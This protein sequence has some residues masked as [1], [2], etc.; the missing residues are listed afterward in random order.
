LPHPAHQLIAV[1]PWHTPVRVARE[2]RRPDGNRVKQLQDHIIY[3]STK[4][5]SR[6]SL[7]ARKESAACKLNATDNTLWWSKRTVEL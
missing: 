1:D 6:E 7:L 4:V 5:H 3:G 2:P